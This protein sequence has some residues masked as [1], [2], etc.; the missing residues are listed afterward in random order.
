M[1]HLRYLNIYLVR[2]KYAF[3]NV[4]TLLINPEAFKIKLTELSVKTSE[5]YILPYGILRALS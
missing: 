1:R 5:S 4:K 2:I 3:Y